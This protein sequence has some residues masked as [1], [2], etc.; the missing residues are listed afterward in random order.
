MRP[1][2]RL[3][4]TLAL[5]AGMLPLVGCAGP[6]PTPFPAAAG[7][8]I[9]DAEAATAAAK[10]LAEIAGPVEAV[11][12]VSGRHDALDPFA[13]NNPGDPAEAAREQALAGRFVWRVTMNGPTGTETIV[14]DAETGE[15]LGAVV[16]GQ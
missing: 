6:A 13:H 15:S 2:A 5:A 11:E 14:I 12:A 3:A 16:Q 10:R 7:L 4:A 1:P 8:P 9:V